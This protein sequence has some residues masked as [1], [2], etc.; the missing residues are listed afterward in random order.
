[1]SYS[2]QAFVMLPTENSPSPECV[3][4][5]L[6][7]VFHASQE[8]LGEQVNPEPQIAID[9][10]CLTISIEDWQMRIYLNCDPCVSIESQDI[11][12]TH[13]ES[14]DP[15]QAA[16]STCGFRLE[17]SCDLD[18]HLDRFNYYINVLEALATF[19]GAIIFNP[20]TTGF[21]E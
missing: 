16:L 2:Y 20:S 17:L 18:P 14:A 9:S 13:L 12:A 15:K 8:R 3:K 7:Q 10:D 6:Q 11:A 4:D 21:I 19:P 5:R 1:M